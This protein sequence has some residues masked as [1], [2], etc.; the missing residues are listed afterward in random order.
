VL[1]ESEL[2]S[3]RPFFEVVRRVRVETRLITRVDELVRRVISRV[4]KL[5]SEIILYYTVNHCITYESFL[6]SFILAI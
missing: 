5:F 3:V 2:E 6:T 1:G 4:L